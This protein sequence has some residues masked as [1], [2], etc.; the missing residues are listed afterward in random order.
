MVVGCNLHYYIFIVKPN[1]QAL[2]NGD[3]IFS[4]RATSTV[5]SFILIAANPKLT[6][7]DIRW[8]FMP[9]SSNET[10][11][12]TTSDNKYTFSFDMLTLTV[13]DTQ[14]T[15]IGEYKIVGL[16][17]VG[18]GEAIITLKDVYGKLALYLVTKY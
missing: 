1:F 5:I 3:D 9:S 15:D 16:N 4:T 8:Y 17:T 11:E 14:T 10:V 2:N 13:K 18:T 12:I 7:S 6:P